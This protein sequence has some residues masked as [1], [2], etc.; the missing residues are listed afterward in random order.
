MKW[1]GMRCP[2]CKVEVPKGARFCPSCGY[3]PFSRGNVRLSLTLGSAAIVILIGVIISN[4]I[5]EDWI[6]AGGL[7][8]VVGIWVYMLAA[9]FRHGRLAEPSDQET[10]VTSDGR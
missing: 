10:T 7:A 6:P 1:R 3:E 5:A 8:I 2:K 4:V 9:H